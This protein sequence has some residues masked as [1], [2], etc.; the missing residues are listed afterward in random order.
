M[1][2][3]ELNYSSA[4]WPSQAIRK[5]GVRAAAFRHVVEGQRAFGGRSDAKLQGQNLFL[6]DDVGAGR[7]LASFQVG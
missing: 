4:P 3:R 2:K 7:V 6:A 5:P 1:V